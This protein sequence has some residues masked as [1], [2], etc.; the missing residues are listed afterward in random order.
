MFTIS[1]VYSVKCLYSVYSAVIPIYCSVFSI[2][3]VRD[4]TFPGNP[5]SGNF[6]GIFLEVPGNFREHSPNGEIY[7]LADHD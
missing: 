7:N 2:P 6:P 3:I 4:G 5:V 1:I